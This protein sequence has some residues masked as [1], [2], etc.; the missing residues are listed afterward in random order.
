[1]DKNAISYNICPL[2]G[3]GTAHFVLTI[4]Q[5]IG[6]IILILY[7]LSC[8]SNNLNTFKTNIVLSRHILDNSTTRTP[9]TGRRLHKKP[10]LRKISPEINTATIQ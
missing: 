3:G 4:A 1:M 6:R 8:M 2:V 9:L 10:T 7:N 5:K